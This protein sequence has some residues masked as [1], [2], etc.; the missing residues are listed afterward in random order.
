MRI[1]VTDKDIKEGIRCSTS[2]CPVARALNRKFENEIISV[3]VTTFTIGNKIYPM[4][5]KAQK[6]IMNFDS[7][8]DPARINFKL[9]I[10]NEV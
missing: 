4:P 10:P 7:Q 5:K 9:D 6:F 8:R 1:Y 2:R 3:G